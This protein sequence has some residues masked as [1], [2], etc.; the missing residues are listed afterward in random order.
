M[1]IT[2]RASTLQF[3]PI[4]QERL[5]DFMFSMQLTWIRNSLHSSSHVTSDSNVTISG[6]KELAPGTFC[7]LHKKAIVAGW[8][9]CDKKAKRKCSGTDD[10]E[11]KRERES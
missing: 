7:A 2:S 5:V 9:H 11:G 1:E 6:G 4:S 8:L 3:G 10:S